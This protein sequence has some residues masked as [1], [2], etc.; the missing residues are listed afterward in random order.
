MYFYFYGK[1]YLYLVILAFTLSNGFGFFALGWL[2]GDVAM[3][4]CWMV[5]LFS[6]FNGKNICKL[7]NDPIAKIIFILLGYYILVA[8]KC[9]LYKSEKPVECINAI[10]AEMFYF[11]YFVFKNIKYQDYIKA[12]KIIFIVTTIA[13]VFYFLQFIGIS[14][15]LIGKADEDGL[16]TF[17]RFRNAPIFT[18]PILLYLLYD[19]TKFKFKPFIILFYFGLLIMPMSRGYIL[20]FIIANVGIGLFYGKY[21]NISKKLIYVI[22]AL[23]VF[24]PII[25]YRFVESSDTENEVHSAFNTNYNENQIDGSLQF[26]IALAYERF[27]YLLKHPDMIPLGSGTLSEH[28]AKNKFNFNIGSSN[29][30]NENVIFKQQLETNDISF[31]THILKFGI[32]YLIIYIILLIIIFQQ[33]IRNHQM[34]LGYIGLILLSI[35]IIQCLGSDGFQTLGQMVFVFLCLGFCFTNRNEPRI[36]LKSIKYGRN[37]YS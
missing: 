11:A 3:A 33:L 2:S 28:S 35:K 23:I 15:F 9:W 4:M 34:L 30:N 19:K 27:E 5:C 18:T 32:I 21:F 6:A 17:S 13:G 8:I 26:R 36:N 12:F 25:I 29:I 22:I 24:S 37:N 16:A 10:R 14:G 1:K 31:V 7:K 20:S